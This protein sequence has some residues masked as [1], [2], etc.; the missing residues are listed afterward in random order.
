MTDYKVGNRILIDAILYTV[1]NVDKNAD[2]SYN[3]IFAISRN[4][5]IVNVLDDT[6]EDLRPVKF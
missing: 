5:K 4:N 2:D 6:L 3:A 1:Y